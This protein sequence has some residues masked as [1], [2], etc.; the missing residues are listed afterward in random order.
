MIRRSSTNNATYLNSPH[1]VRDACQNLVYLKIWDQEAEY[2]DEDYSLAVSRNARLYTGQTQNWRT[3]ERSLQPYLRILQQ[4]NFQFCIGHSLTNPYHRDALEVATIA[5]IFYVFGLMQINRSPY[6]IH[7]YTQI[8]EDIDVDNIT[9]DHYRAQLGW[10][11]WRYALLVGTAP[12]QNIIDNPRYLPFVSQNPDALMDL[13]EFRP[14]DNGGLVRFLDLIGTEGWPRFL[15]HYPAMVCER[16]STWGPRVSIQDIERADV[17]LVRRLETHQ[18]SLAVMLGQRPTRLTAD[19]AANQYMINVCGKLTAK[20][21]PN[22]RCVL[23]LWVVHPSIDPRISWNKQTY[24][25]LM[26]MVPL[27]VNVIEKILHQM[28]IKFQEGQEAGLSEDQ[29]HKVINWYQNSLLGLKISQ[30]TN[31]L[32]EEWNLSVN[33]VEQIEPLD[34]EPLFNIEDLQRLP[35]EIA[36]DE[37]SDDSVALGTVA[38][39]ILTSGVH[40]TL[41]RT[42]KFDTRIRRR[43]KTRNPRFDFLSDAAKANELAS[44]CFLIGQEFRL[45][46]LRLRKRE[47]IFVPTRGESIEHQMNK[48][49]R[50][51]WDTR[52]AA[53]SHPE[54]TKSESAQKVLHLSRGWQFIVGDFHDAFPRENIFRLLLNDLPREDCVLNA[55]QLMLL[56]IRTIKK[57]PDNPQAVTLSERY[58]NCFDGILIYSRH[59]NM[60]QSYSQ[61]A[62][63]NGLKN[64]FQDLL[65]NGHGVKIGYRSATSF[66]AAAYRTGSVLRNMPLYAFG[67]AY[68]WPASSLHLLEDYDLFD[69]RATLRTMSEESHLE[70]L[71]NR[72]QS[73]TVSL[74]CSSIGYLLD[75]FAPMQKFML[76]EL[77]DQPCEAAN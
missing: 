7:W 76:R 67:M 53:S 35:T 12:P 62:I 13:R 44:E 46:V 74:Y 73:N 18:V 72:F 68:L 43:C 14:L 63:M 20:N 57:F 41:F 27:T 58:N 64:A 37:V 19:T 4:P 55:K 77:E 21:L 70:V 66:E 60:T 69:Y 42:K 8:S 32:R 11:A 17:S 51:E 56:L 38:R 33:N 48:C 50:Q 23:L 49:W 25:A 9:A 28:G 5:W 29:A 22:G 45:T 15:D 3:R 26:Q 61:M 59:P 34:N 75:I 52:I 10:T 65:H 31:R 1:T 40:Q 6:A 47:G 16:M 24:L 2:E 30:L 71:S 39:Q 36:I 54:S